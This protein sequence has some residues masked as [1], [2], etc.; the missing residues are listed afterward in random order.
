MHSPISS[1]F[2][3]HQKG[4]RVS[5]LAEQ[6]PAALLEHLLEGYARCR[7][8]YDDS[9]E[10]VDWLY[11][12]VNPAFERLTGLRDA[13]GKRVSDL[14]PGVIEADPE[15]L[16]AYARVAAGG[17]PEQFEI[18]FT[19]LRCWL[20]VSAFSPAR[21]DF[22]AIF[23]DV[24]SHKRAEH[25][26]CLLSSA[27]EEASVGIVIADASARILRV[28]RR[29]S[30][31]LGSTPGE[32]KAKSLADIDPDFSLDVWPE[33][34]ASLLQGAHMRRTRI[35]NQID[36]HSVPLELHLSVVQSDGQ[37]VLVGVAHEIGERLAAEAALAE[38]Q[39]RLTTLMGNLPGMAYR[40][41]NDASWTMEFASAGCLE[42]TG[43]PPQAL[44]GNDVLSYADV[45]DEEDR[46]KVWGTV[47]DRVEQNETWELTYRIRTASGER[48]W[49]WERGVS[50]RDDGGAVVA[51]EG[52]ITDM[53]AQH[54][55]E[56]RLSAAA[57]QW[58]DTFDAMHDCI[59][60]LDDDGVI[61][62]CN[63][64]ARE[65]TGRSYKELLGR[66]CYEVLHG[67]DDF[68]PDCPHRRSMR[69][70]KA[71]TN[72]LRQ[73][74]RWLRSTFQPGAGGQ[75]GVHVLTD[76]TELKQAEGRL[77]DSLTR[78]QVVTEGVIDA[79]SRTVEVRDPYTAGHERRVSQLAVAIARELGLDEERTEGLRVAGELHDV[80]KII[81]P[82][83]ILA[84]PGRLTE[85]EFALIKA[86]SETSFEI[87]Q[88]I[89]FPWPLAEMARQ[90]HER[91][92]GSGY[93]QGLA[94][95]EILLEAR[96]LAVADVVE[97]MSSY[98]P[99]RP[100][101]GMDAALAEIE[102]NRGRLYDAAVV[103]GCLRVV[104]DEGFAFS[105]DPSPR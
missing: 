15:L 104:R 100:A 21:G 27:M 28:N 99:Y 49:V 24:T 77:T 62:R 63:A 37:D 44:V 33:Y 81:V 2:G 69:S 32:L 8:L 91:M 79:I 56:E 82:A 25:D 13:V 105:A 60:V 11:L 73:D 31:L 95:E 55:A 6:L 54:Q 38:R 46:A 16:S 94:G 10:A 57:A 48:K 29:M 80:G 30:E 87:L 45:I 43:Y 20:R 65:M 74:G 47:E 72:I 41:A 4:G 58:R 84:S 1:T 40:C 34:W 101:L 102:A 23:E 18:F 78:L 93:P 35:V 98:R 17:A 7:M 89:D 3:S 26:V 59:L 61:L 50:V 53:T 19:P 36:G 39:R 51:L 86:H 22:V 9:G 90:H 103:D 14:I 66:H 92:D 52:F 97:A 70:G 71:E 5:E 83:E 75:G 42:L 12:A 67:S 96:I 88:S 64:A 85:W 76:I 68:H